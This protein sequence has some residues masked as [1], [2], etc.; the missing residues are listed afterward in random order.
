[1]MTASMS[2]CLSSISRKSLYLAAFVYASRS[3]M[4]EGE[5]TPDSRFGRSR[6]ANCRSIYPGS[7]SQTATRFSPAS[8]SSAVL[9]MPIPPNPTMATLSVSDG[10]RLEAV[11][12]RTCLGMIIAPRANLAL[13]ATKSRRVK[14]L[15]KGSGRRGGPGQPA[16]APADTSLAFHS[17]YREWHDGCFAGRKIGRPVLGHTVRRSP[18]PQ[19]RRDLIEARLPK[20][21]L[22]MHE[23]VPQSVPA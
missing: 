12:P 15:M 19:N 20:A 3:L 23:H 4:A 17:R 7:M 18:N 6:P 22:A 8:T 1:M 11:A 9:F 10:A 13:S 21:V 2:F 14:G 16:A 5:T